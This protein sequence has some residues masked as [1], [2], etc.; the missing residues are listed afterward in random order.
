MFQL[1]ILISL[2]YFLLA[3][4]VEADS[5]FPLYFGSATLSQAPLPPPGLLFVTFFPKET[6]IIPNQYSTA[7]M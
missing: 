6:I 4:V 5:D 2:P 3:E 1:V 7:E